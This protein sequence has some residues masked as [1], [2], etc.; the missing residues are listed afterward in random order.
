MA[1]GVDAAHD[2]NTS[3]LS[4]NDENSLACVLSIAY[5]YAS[6]DYIIHREL[7]TGKGFADLVL[8]PRKNVD[9]PAIIIELKYNKAVDTAID[10]IHCKQYPAKVAQ[11][12]NLPLS[13]NNAQLSTLNSHLLL[14][15]ITYDRDTKQHQCRIESWTETC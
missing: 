3:I 5:Y 11:Y 1:R 6:N 12:L 13:K 2:E 9:S 4:Y 14:V 15:G 8:I 7:A 10:Q